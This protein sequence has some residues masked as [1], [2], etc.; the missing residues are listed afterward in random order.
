MIAGHGCTSTSALVVTCPRTGIDEVRLKGD[1]LDDELIAAVDPPEQIDVRA[2]GGRGSDLLQ[3]GNGEDRLYGQSGNDTLSG[4]SLVDHY[5]AGSG[6]DTVL[7]L[8]GLREIVACSSGADE[9]S[10]DTGVPAGGGVFD[11]V[12]GC[13]LSL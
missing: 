2:Y 8:D 3:T 6:D 9:A 11:R 10:A 12:I 7:A 5:N 4:Q 1:D 13:E